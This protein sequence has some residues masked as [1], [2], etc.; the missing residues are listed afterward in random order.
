MGVVKGWVSDFFIV[1]FE[2]PAPKLVS[3]PIFSL[4]GPYFN[5]VGW[6]VGVGV[7]GGAVDFQVFCD[8]IID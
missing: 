4:I 1:R 3:V 8:D 7:V 2:L 5:L 6:G